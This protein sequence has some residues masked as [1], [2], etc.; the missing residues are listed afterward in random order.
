MSTRRGSS[1]PPPFSYGASGSSTGWGRTSKC[2]P[3]ELSAY[4]IREIILASVARKSSTVLPLYLTAVGLNR[5]VLDH[6]VLGSKAGLSL[7]REAVIVI[8]PL[9]NCAARN[10]NPVT[11]IIDD[12]PVF[13]GAQRDPVMQ[14][15]SG[16]RPST[17]LFYFLTLSSDL[18]CASN[19][20]SCALVECSSA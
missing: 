6:E 20:F 11:L 19:D 16:D 15:V 2:S 10:R 8:C 18:R 5:P 7:R 12:V 17:A 1:T 3:S 13:G 14:S 4:P 9:T